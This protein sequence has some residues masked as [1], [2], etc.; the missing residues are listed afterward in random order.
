MPIP[1][2]ILDGR[3]LASSFRSRLVPQIAQFNTHY[4]PLCLAVVLVGHNPASQIY[5][6]NK[7]TFCAEV[8]ILSQVHHLPNHSSN[9][10]VLDCVRQLND[11]PKVHGILLQLPLPEQLDSQEILETI[12]P[13]KDVD[14]LTP[15][16]MGC[17]MMGKPRLVPCTPYGCLQLLQWVHPSLSGKQVTI[18]GRSSL[19][20]KP[21]AAL[22]TN[23][24][25]TVTLAHSHTKNLKE[26]CSQ[27]D[28]LVCAMGIP[29]K[30][31]AEYVK[32]LATVIDVGINRID[33]GSE[34]IVG[35]VDFK[36]VFD[37]VAHITPVPGGVGPMTIANLLGN[38]L[39]AGK[40]QKQLF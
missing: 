5:V 30:I 24:N 34:S 4:G 16:N 33:Y 29:Q 9:K 39:T 36:N 17:L 3:L 25:A 31:T 32:P 8:G 19:V 2:K 37:T 7:Q 27:A 14:G 40:L 21:L 28:I 26:I 11:D 1:Q 15:Y 22:L 13:L 10:D 35:D 23:H 6:S 38:T 20:G 12:D 18:V